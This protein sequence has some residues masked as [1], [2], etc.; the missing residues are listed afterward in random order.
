[1]L[2]GAIA[3]RVRC[4][5]TKNGILVGR[6]LYYALAVSFSHVPAVDGFDITAPYV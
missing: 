3:D 4:V 5:A 2:S 6:R 1:M